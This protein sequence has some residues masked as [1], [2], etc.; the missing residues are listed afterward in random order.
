MLLGLRTLVGV[1]RIQII[2]ISSE[3]ETKS[4]SR[5]FKTRHR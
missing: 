2:L 1:K 5:S 3:H 4:R